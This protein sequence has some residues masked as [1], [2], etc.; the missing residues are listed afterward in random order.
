MFQDVKCFLST[1]STILS[2]K[3]KIA[4]GPKKNV[5]LHYV[6][7]ARLLGGAFLTPV[8]VSWTYVQTEQRSEL[9]LAPANVPVEW[10]KRHWTV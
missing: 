1:F 9:K 5:T 8:M 7:S 3:S 10:L 2:F 4:S 6:S